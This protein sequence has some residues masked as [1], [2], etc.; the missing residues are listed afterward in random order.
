MISS[1]IV[2]SEALMTALLPLLDGAK[3][4]IHA[5]TRPA[6]GGGA[7]APLAELAFA[8]PAGEVVG[9]ALLISE[10]PDALAIA[11]GVPTWARVLDSDDAWLFD[12]DARASSAPDSG[13][14]L[15]V[16]NAEQV[17]E[18]DSLRIVSGS[19]MAGV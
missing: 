10:G 13:Q 19:F 9:A 18:V 5:G 8:S 2:V 6:P 17:T 11:S 12:C 16:G 15:V 7:L 4:Q 14:E 1:S 3:V